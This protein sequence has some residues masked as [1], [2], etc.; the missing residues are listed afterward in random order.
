MCE[1]SLTGNNTPT[2]APT[3]V[4][5]RVYAAAGVRTSV[6]R[7]QLRNVPEDFFN[8]SNLSGFYGW[9]IVGTIVFWPEFVSYRLL[10]INI[11]ARFVF[12]QGFSLKLNTCRIINYQKSFFSN[13]ALA[14]LNLVVNAQLL[15]VS[16]SSVP[17]RRAD[18]PSEI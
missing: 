4:I 10:C 7:H 5:R 11:F 17:C 13:S 2:I 15:R 9:V 1:S 16:Y 12:K 18:F 6:Y 3:P 14:G 8:I